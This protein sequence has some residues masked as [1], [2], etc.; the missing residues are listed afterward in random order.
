MTYCTFF[1]PL[2]A[3]KKTTFSERFVNIS[4]NKTLKTPINKGNSNF[5]VIDHLPRQ[6]GLRRPGLVTAHTSLRRH[7]PSTKTTRIK[8]L[9]IIIFCAF[10]YSHR[11][12]TKTTR[13]KTV[14]AGWACDCEGSHRPSTKTTR[15]KTALLQLV[16]TVGVVIDHLPRQQ[17]LR[18]LFHTIFTENNLVI[19][20][21]PRQQGLRRTCGK[22]TQDTFGS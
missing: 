21:L 9:P 20:H 3:E 16:V 22:R 15:I 2:Q 5:S 1:V 17:G 4:E 12:S 13:I 6:Q 11:P 19:D 10:Y 8:T 14:S 7:R 18:L